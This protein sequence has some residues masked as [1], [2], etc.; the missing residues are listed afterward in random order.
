M[1][2]SS[3]LNKLK[4]LDIRSPWLVSIVTEL[5]NRRGASAGIE[6]LYRDSRKRLKAAQDPH[7]RKKFKQAVND[8]IKYGLLFEKQAK[9]GTRLHLLTSVWEIEDTIIESIAKPTYDKSMGRRNSI[10]WKTILKEVRK[11]LT[12]HNIKLPYQVTETLVRYFLL[13]RCR[14]KLLSDNNIQ[15]PSKPGKKLTLSPEHQHD[16][17]V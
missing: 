9:T 8:L 1:N 13:K 15:P 11:E 16:L 6:P 3:I 10:N 2:K 12:D 14:W 17:F 7:A 4:L 5:S